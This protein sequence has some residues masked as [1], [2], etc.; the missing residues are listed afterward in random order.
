[1]Q[2]SVDRLVRLAKRERNSIRPYLFVNPLQG[3]H[4]PT[5]PDDAIGMCQQMAELINS[6]YPEDR[7][8]VIGFAETAT[9]IAASVS[10]FLKNIVYYQNTTREQDGSDHLFFSEAHSHATDQL[11]RTSG[12]GKALQSVDRL[13]FIDD[14]VTTGNT[15]CNLIRI[16][17]T[18]FHAHH[19]KYTILS[20]L[21]SMSESR[22]SEVQTQGVDCLFLCKLPYEYQ[23]DSI[24]GVS[25]DA[26]RHILATESTAQ[27]HHLSISCSINPRNMVSFVDY[28]KANRAFVEELRK[29]LLNDKMQ[30]NNVLVLG[31]EE[32]MYPTFVVGEMIK[33][34][35]YSKN[36]RIHSTT[37]SP[38]LASGQDG[39]PLTSRYQIRSP[40]DSQRTTYIY[41]LQQYDKVFILTDAAINSEGNRDLCGALEYVG[42][43]DISIIQWR[44]NEDKETV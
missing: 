28:M 38:I 22:L 35:G 13:V 20:V 3:K 14:E 6:A 16:I 18:G 1:M 12:M 27:H 7:L 4:I 37:R 23:K 43:S 44:Y 2:W 8:Y 26:Q 17:Q 21:N 34:Q 19:L 25:F 40:Y 31:T 10:S 29:Y 41:N 24:M 36:V 11:L 9:G 39:Y 30:L 15:I 5:S 33:Q 32:F 42:N